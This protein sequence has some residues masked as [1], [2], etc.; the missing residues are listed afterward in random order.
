MKSEQE[1]SFCNE[2]IG[3]SLMDLQKD[4]YSLLR[5][6]QNNYDM[7]F[8][9]LHEFNCYD[10]D[11]DCIDRDCDDGLSLFIIY[12]NTYYGEFNDYFE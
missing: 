6:I 11:I 7:T 3:L 9:E 5:D 8:E 4:C 2:L 10:S 1:I 12:D